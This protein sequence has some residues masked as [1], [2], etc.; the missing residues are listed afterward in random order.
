MTLQFFDAS[1][2]VNVNSLKRKRKNRLLYLQK[3]EDEK[4]NE[5]GEQN[6]QEREGDETI[7]NTNTWGDLLY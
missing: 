2:L 1:L 7:E 4:G 6:V 5:R 3:I